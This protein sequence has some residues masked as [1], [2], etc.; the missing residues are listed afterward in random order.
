MFIIRLIINMVMKVRSDN[1]SHHLDALLSAQ[2]CGIIAQHMMD[3]DKI[4]YKQFD[5]SF[6][7]TCMYIKNNF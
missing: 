6:R 5:L 4:Y 3:K 2:L 7:E 1:K